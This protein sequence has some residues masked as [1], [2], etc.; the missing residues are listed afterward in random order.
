MATVT[1]EDIMAELKSVHREIR[2]I[3]Q[4]LEDP[5][6][7]KAKA[8]SENSTFKRPMKV[9]DK[10][11]AFLKLGP[12]EQVSRADV[13]KR[14]NQYIKDNNL[15]NGSAIVPDAALQEVLQVPQDALATLTS[16]RLTKYLSPHFVKTETDDATAKPARPKVRAAA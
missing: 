2:K 11:H 4:K 3:R 6:G 5:D 1:V 15:K 14:V 16:L 8:R 7:V 13:S 10:L 12:D 9:S